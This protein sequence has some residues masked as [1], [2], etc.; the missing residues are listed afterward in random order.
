MGDV[1]CRMDGDEF[2]PG[3]YYVEDL[4]GAEM[5]K[6]RFENGAVG[7]FSEDCEYH[8]VADCSCNG[9]CRP[10][11]ECLANAHLFAASLEMLR[12]LRMAVAGGAGWETAAVAAIE[13]ATKGGE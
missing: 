8:M 13:H 5:D 4:H 6:C 10:E 9:S 12:A 2:T 11:S 1:P 7:V 3:P